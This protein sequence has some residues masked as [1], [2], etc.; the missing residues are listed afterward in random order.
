[1]LSGDWERGERR[2]LGRRRLFLPLAAVLA[3][4]FLRTGGRA[5]LRIMNKQ[6]EE[7]SEHHHAHQVTQ[8]AMLPAVGA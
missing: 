1:L 3:V 8:D 4:R 7:A 5:S 2:R 6:M